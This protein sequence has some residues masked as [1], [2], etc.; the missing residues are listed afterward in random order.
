MS[1]NDK[2]TG[3]FLGISERRRKGVA[4]PSR[5]VSKR[6]ENMPLPEAGQENDELEWARRH[7]P[8][9]PVPRMVE[10]KTEIIGCGVRFEK[11]KLVS[12]TAEEMLR[13]RIRI[14]TDQQDRKQEEMR[15]QLNTLRNRIEK[16][17]DLVAPLK[18]W[19]QS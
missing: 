13:K 16:I 10:R 8:E 9:E 18:E 6:D 19:G 4:G 1:T 2:T 17:E 11:T 3:K 15:Q 5:E 12:L 14:I 7:I